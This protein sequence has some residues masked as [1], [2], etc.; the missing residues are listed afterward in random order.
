M[1]KTQDVNSEFFLNEKVNFQRKTK[2]RQ[3]M[4]TV[5]ESNLFADDLNTF[6]QLSRMKKCFGENKK[7]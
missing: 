3:E 7:S 2:Y 6:E 1:I 4:T 5:P